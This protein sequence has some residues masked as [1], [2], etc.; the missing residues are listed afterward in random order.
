MNP[1]EVHMVK[2]SII[3]LTMATLA[4][5]SHAQSV[6]H[7]DTAPPPVTAAEPAPAPAPTPAVAPAPP[8]PVDVKVEPVYFDY[9]KAELKPAGQEFLSQ[10]GALLAKHP[11]LHVRIEGNC[12][13]RGTAQYNIA[14][15]SRRAEAAK[16]YLVRMGAKT[17]QITT[18]SYGKERPLAKGHDEHAWRQ[19][20]RDDLVPDQKSVSADPMAETP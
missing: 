9:D 2:L 13:E 4:G 7:A 14:L 15:G 1:R 18:V 20:R 17:D 6:S 19:N 16:S 8:A 11:E 3:G 12:D 5:C 10:F